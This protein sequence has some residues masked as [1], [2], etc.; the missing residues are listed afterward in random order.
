MRRLQTGMTLMELMVAITLA[1]LLLLGVV[2]IFIS[3]KRTYT[4]EDALSRVQESGRF[5]L[6]FIA[7]D[8]RM[9]GYTGCPNLY[10]LTPNDVRNN[11]VLTFDQDNYMEAYNFTDPGWH[12]TVPATITNPAPVR[13]DIIVFGRA[14]ECS[15][16]L[17]SA[18]ASETA[19]LAVNAGTSC[20]F[21]NNEPLMITDC[22][23]A[24]MFYGEGIAAPF[25]GTIGHGTATAD[26]ASGA[27][28]KAYTLGSQV[29]NFQSFAYYIGTSTFTGRPSLFRQ[30]DG[31]APV[32]LVEDV[33][34]LQIELGE[35]TNNSQTAN[36]YVGPDDVNLDISRV[37]SMRVHVVVRS[38]RTDLQTG[39]DP[40]DANKPAPYVL[41]GTN[42]TPPDRGVYRV[43]T[44]TVTLRNRTL[45]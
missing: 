3:S 45:D 21:N 36:R 24:D 37:V 39:N 8:L 1:S 29:T 9:A 25:T 38:E 15:A 13:G 44:T 31:G 43:Y 42:V 18:M 16:P 22:I 41:M 34:D 17:T 30:V 2:N 12:T 20:S 10:R 33:Y 28:S 11:T 14:G 27:F 5:A 32:E 4:M 7:F 6:D 19:N 23:N 40:N 26:N 35:D